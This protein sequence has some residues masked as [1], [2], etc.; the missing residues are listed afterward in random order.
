MRFHF[1]SYKGDYNGKQA[2]KQNILEKALSDGPSANLRPVDLINV[3]KVSILSWSQ[4][5]NLVYRSGAFGIPKN[6]KITC[7]AR[8][9]QIFG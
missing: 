7:S 9:F 6:V 1:F 5:L 2:Q 3:A 4:Q 8:I